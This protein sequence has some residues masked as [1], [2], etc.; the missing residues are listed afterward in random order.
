MGCRSLLQRILG[1]RRYGCALGSALPPRVRRA[2]LPILIVAFPASLLAQPSVAFSSPVGS[3]FTYTKQVDEVNMLFTVTDRKG[4]LVSD[5]GGQDFRLLDNHEAPQ[6]IHYF[7]KQSE[8]P[9]KVGVLIDISGSVSHRLSFEKRGARI[10]LKKILR[11]GI[12]EAFVAAFDEQPH[13][14]QDL[15][16]NTAGMAGS[17]DHIKAGGG[18]RL[19]DAIIFAAE[20]LGATREPKV[21][22]RAIVLITDGEDNKSKALL[23][24]AQ[25]A[26]MRSDTVIFALSTNDVRSDYPK[27]EAILKLLTQATGGA[28][29]PAREDYELNRAFRDIE[30]TLRSQYAMGY[31]PAGFE[32]DGSFH[33]VE[34]VPRRP[35]LTVRSRR[36]YFAAKR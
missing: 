21:T 11:P 9:L 16:N 4:R 35:G 14:L 32:A 24:D 8:L 18:T 23:S 1:V 25:Q 2:L 7:Q 30:K 19:F 15:T 10:F 31:T 26:A 17:F 29:L 3:A 28:I 12:D 20:K 22:R 34:I 27:G 6:R 33:A 36:G 5:L 13:L